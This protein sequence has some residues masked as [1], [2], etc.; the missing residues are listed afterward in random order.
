MEYSKKGIIVQCV[1]PGFV[2]SNMS[3]IRRASLIAPTAKTFVKSAISLVGTTS[4]TT[5]YFPHSI[6]VNTINAIYGV[7]AKFAVW[8][9][10]RSME[11]TRRKALKKYKNK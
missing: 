6:F 4:K 5:G 9:V 10:T 11:N 1:L 8:L 7:S 3:G 2:C